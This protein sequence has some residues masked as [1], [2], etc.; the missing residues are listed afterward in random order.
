M[1]DIE[2]SDIE[3]KLDKIIKRLK[4][5]DIER[6][7]QLLLRFESMNLGV[8]I[9]IFT[10]SL[11]FIVSENFFS[12][13]HEFLSVLLVFIMGNSLFLI[14]LQIN[15]IYQNNLKKRLDFFGG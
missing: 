9:L 1:G 2:L 11:S 15:L 8:L 13:V 12:R 7:R 3:K 6:E 14:I 10:I 5:Q 4:E